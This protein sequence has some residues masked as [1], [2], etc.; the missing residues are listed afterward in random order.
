MTL[1]IDSEPYEWTFRRIMG[2]TLLVAFVVFCF[3]LLYMFYGVLFAVTVS[4][5]AGTLISPAVDWLARRGLPRRAGVIIVYLLLLGLLV[6]F[7]LLLFPL[8][9]EQGTTI[10]AALSDYYLGIR[11]WF[12][13]NSNP[14]ILRM[15]EFLPKA[16]PR[17]EQ[18]PQSGQQLLDS[19]GQVLGYGASAARAVF[20]ATAMLLLAYHWALTGPR[21]M[22]SILRLAPAGPRDSISDL[23]TAIETKVG[24]YLAGQ[25]VLCLAVGLLALVAYLLIGLP[26][27]VVLALIAG[28]L[29]A[30]PIVGPLLGA[31]PAA[32]VALGIAPSKLLWVIAATLAIQQLESAFLVP[33][34]MRKA[35]GV[36]PFV[37]LLAI[38]AFSS[39]FGI[40]GALMAIPMA[41][42]LQLLLDRFFF[43]ST[44]Q[45]T[46]ISAGRDYAS[47]LRYEANELVADLRKLARLD[48][49]GSEEA[50]EQ[51]DQAMDE[52]EA[53]ATDLDTLLAQ[54]VRTDE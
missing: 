23:V 52:I 2:A 30:V 46:V 31:V 45:E 39:L 43:H 19:A 5:V 33:R 18:D 13:G 20:M 42:V 28:V 9:V 15:G 16:L 34:V 21:T 44:V 38:S 29:E 7:A 8:L 27:A 48:V 17:L 41:A 25:G 26:N 53:I 40:A 51:L 35:V 6:G 1:Q 36:N 4:I 24:Y 3:W 14:L 32:L 22:Q 37:S 49:T 50:V 54:A 12:V 11:A 47:R 10:S